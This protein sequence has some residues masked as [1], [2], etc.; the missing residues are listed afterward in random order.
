MISVEEMARVVGETWKSL[1]PAEKQP[2]EAVAQAEMAAFLQNKRAFEVLHRQLKQVPCYRQDVSF[3][4]GAGKGGRRGGG[5]KRLRSNFYPYLDCHGPC[6]EECRLHLH[7]LHYHQVDVFARQKEI[8]GEEY[9]G[10]VK[11]KVGPITAQY[12]G[13]VKIQEADEANHTVAMRAQA[14]K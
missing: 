5:G 6:R 11:V 12:K 1:S 8:A 7:A 9:R 2:Y 13:T 10:V 4:R 14:K 3:F